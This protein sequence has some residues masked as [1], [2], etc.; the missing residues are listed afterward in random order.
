MVGGR[1]GIEWSLPVPIHDEAGYPRPMEKV[2]TAPDAFLASFDGDVGET[3]TALDA[4]ISSCLPGRS[5]TVWEG[6]FWGGTEQRILGYGD[7]LQPRPR[8]ASV[9]WF[10]VG[11][12]RQTRT[13]SVY[14]NAVED[15]AYLLK[16]YEGR[17]GKVKLGSASIGFADAADLDRDA[18]AE[19]LRRAHDL[20]P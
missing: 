12:A 6:T 17:L 13:Y 3:M 16:A 11:L 2:D 18:F 1:T 20:S 10:L 14:V 7:L 4:L 19:L 9:E 8:G 15:G 5:R